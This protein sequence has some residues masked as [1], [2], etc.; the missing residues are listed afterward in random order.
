AA[1]AAA[2]TIDLDSQIAEGRLRGA[3]ASLALGHTAP[4]L[5]QLRRDWEA[6][7]RAVSD[8]Q[9]H[10]GNPSPITHHDS[11]G[12]RFICL[13]EDVTAKDLEQAVAE[14]FDGI[15]TLKRYSTVNM[16]PCQGKMCGTLATEVCARAT[17][18]PIG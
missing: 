1:G 17:D 15:E 4:S 10:S 7:C 6:Q 3:E 14:G 9:T 8:R 18:R 12:K 16:G 2:G 11:S 5:D 13:C